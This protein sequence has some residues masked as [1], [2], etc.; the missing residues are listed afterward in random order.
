MELKSYQV[1]DIRSKMFWS[2]FKVMK[3]HGKLNGYVEAHLLN[4]YSDFSLL[5]ID[6]SNQVHALE[7]ISIAYEIMSNDIS[8]EV[9]IDKA[10]V[11]MFARY[12]ME[13]NEP[14]SLYIENQESNLK[15]KLKESLDYYVNSGIFDE[16]EM[17]NLV[18]GVW[19]NFVKVCV[20]GKQQVVSDQLGYILIFDKKFTFKN[21]NS[22]PA[23]S[24]W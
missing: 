8:R 20:G 13:A 5:N 15:S 3:I 18:S 17:N 1:D 4:M 12:V 10:V 11:N 6:T 24:I 9:I 23:T 19:S 16:H 22:K 14:Y 21:D 7:A 2:P